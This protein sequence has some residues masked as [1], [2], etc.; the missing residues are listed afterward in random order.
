MAINKDLIIRERRTGGCKEKLSRGEIEEMVISLCVCVCVCV[1]V[2]VCVC[3][4]VKER[5]KEDMLT[6]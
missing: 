2:C 1:Y 3:V 5:V 6:C 4:L